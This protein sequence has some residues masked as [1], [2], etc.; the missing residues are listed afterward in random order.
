MTGAVGTLSNADASEI[1]ARGAECV[2]VVRRDQ[3][4]H[5][6]HAAAAV[7][8]DMIAREGRKRRIEAVALRGDVSSDTGDNLGIAVLHGARR[9]LDRNDATGAA[10]GKI[11]QEA[12]RQPEHIRQRRAVVR[13]QEIA[14]YR[15]PIDIRFGKSRTFD[16][17]AERT[18]EKPRHGAPAGARI[19]DGHRYGDG[20]AGVVARLPCH[21][22]AVTTALAE[23]I[24]FL[25]MV[26]MSPRMILPLALR[27]SSAS[28][29]KRT[30]RGTL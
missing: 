27:L 21:A 8:I 14:C 15:Q 9:T 26:S 11:D 5:R 12:R 17:F 13:R 3:R 10:I 1:L 30:S 4:E 16:Q 6:V 23:A 2:H 19:T 22:S 7:G 18:A 25:S 28:A 29:T 20:N 24:S